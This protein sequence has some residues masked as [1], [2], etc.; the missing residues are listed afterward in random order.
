MYK[1][2]LLLL[3][4]LLS[5]SFSA[6]ANFNEANKALNEKDFEHAKMLFLQKAVMG[7]AQA[8]FNLAALYS[9]P[10]SGLANPKAAFAWLFLASE[11]QYPKAEAFAANIFNQLSPTEQKQTKTYTEK[12]VQR[13]GKQALEQSI[14]PTLADTSVQVVATHPFKPAKLIQ[15]TNL[16]LN[17]EVQ[18][19]RQRR[20]AEHNNAIDRQH[21]RM[22]NML[23]G[24]RVGSEDNLFKLRKQPEPGYFVI[25]HDIDENGRVR[26]PELLF[27]WP[28]AV[29]DEIILKTIQDSIY[30]PAMNKKTP[31]NQHNV[32]SYLRFGY[33]GKSSL[34]MGFPS[35]V[36][37]FKSLTR[38]Q[39]TFSQQYQ[40]AQFLRAFGDYV[41]PK[42]HPHFSDVLLNLSQK[43]YAPAQLALA[44]YQIYENNNAAAGLPWLIAA[45][46]NGN[47]TAQY[48]LGKLA[49]NSPNQQIT[50]DL[51][52]ASYWLSQAAEHGHYQAQENLLEFA[53]THLEPTD[54]D[55]VFI[56]TAD[57]WLQNIIQNSQDSAYTVY[58]QAKLMQLQGYPSKAKRYF[59]E[60]IKQAKAVNWAVEN[61]K[62]D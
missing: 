2:Y 41:V 50:P 44:Q 51:N 39:T 62:L 11:Y 43:A 13:Y 22:Q 45:A 55:P 10:Q 28:E 4:I 54:L 31:V 57:T 7:N 26:S 46:K 36:E 9:D 40:Y 29:Y 60:A 27:A 59:N 34:Q 49:L 5:F 17:D 35:Y 1:G 3:T 14:Y 19:K 32:I 42:N 18:F 25:K 6:N 56:S 16:D 61:W 23:T 37:H 47:I 8:Q 53:F 12:L 38:N 24:Y 33:H 15:H 52:K 48:Q 58:L 30:E 21:E 20:V